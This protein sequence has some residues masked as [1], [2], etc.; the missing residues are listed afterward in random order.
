MLDSLL[1]KYQLYFFHVLSLLSKLTFSS[2]G[3]DAIDDW[4]I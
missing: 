2:H 3:S 4:D 1:N